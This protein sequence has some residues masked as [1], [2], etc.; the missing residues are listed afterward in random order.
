MTRGPH[1]GEAGGALPPGDQP[2]GLAAAG[3]RLAANTGFAVADIDLIIFTQVRQP[4]IELVMADLGLPMERGRSP[5]WTAA[6]TPAR[7]ASRSRSTRRS[8]RAG[9]SQGQLVVFIGSGVGYN[10]AGSGVPVGVGHAVLQPVAS[11]GCAS[12]RNLRRSAGQRHASRRRPRGTRQALARA[13]GAGL[14]PHRRAVHLRRRSTRGARALAPAWHGPAWPAPRRPR[15][16]AGAQ[17]RR[18]RRCLFAAAKSG[19][20]LVPLSHPRHADGNCRA[21]SPTAA[22]ARCSTT[23][24]SPTS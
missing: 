7:P 2:R 12:S 19:I 22:C 6:A 16:P 20:V 4:S 18:V 24:S 15:R 23:P 9:S 10:Q 13:P 3:A 14:R 11:T 17:P 1:E 8:S 21:S 5:T